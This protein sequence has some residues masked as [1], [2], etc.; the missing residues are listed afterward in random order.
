MARSGV[1]TLRK[2][3]C[4]AVSLFLAA[5]SAVVFPVVAQAGPGRPVQES[6]AAQAQRTGQP[7]LVRSSLSETEERWAQPD[8]SMTWRQYA[9]PVRVRSGEGWTP[10]DLTLVVREDG[11]IAPRAAAVD[12][13]LS[14]G[15]AEEPLVRLGTGGGEVG[16]GWP[17]E[18]PAPLLDGPTATYT[19][20]L[21]DVDVK[22]TAGVLGFSQ[23][24]VVKTEQAAQNPA[25]RRIAFESHTEGVQVSLAEGRGA[26]GKVNGE[27]VL[28]DALTVTD[29]NGDPLYS[30]NGSWMWDS[31]GSATAAERMAGQGE[32]VRTAVMGTELDADTVAIV[33]DQDFLAAAETQYPVYLDPGYSCTSCGK[34]AHAVVQ[35]GYP[36][37]SNYNANTGDLSDLKAG[38]QNADSSGVS[39]TYLEMNTSPIR[40][41]TIHWANLNTTL[42]YSW[43]GPGSATPTELYRAD[44]LNGSTRWNNQ[45]GWVGAK[46][47]ESNATNQGKAPNVSAVFNATAGVQ[48]AVANNTNAILVLKGSSEGNNSSWRRFELNPSLEVNYNSTPN[49]PSG[50]KMQQGTV[51]CVTGPDRPWIATRT[52]Q[53]L[54]NISDPDGQG[55]QVKVATVGGAYGQDVPGTYHDNGR[56]GPWIGTPGP[57]QPALA[58]YTVPGGWITTDGIYKWAMGVYDGEADSP[59]WDWD[60]EF[61]VNSTPPLAPTVTRAF[62]LPAPTPEDPQ[63]SFHQ[64]D[65]STIT[66]E[67]PLATQGLEDIDRF[68]YT[69]DGSQPSAQGSLSVPVTY[70]TN[71]ANQRIAKATFDVTAVNA[72]QNLLRVK[73]VNKAGTAGPNGS[74]GTNLTATGTGADV[75]CFYVATGLSSAARLKGAWSLDEATGPTGG[76]NVAA[77]TSN[78]TP[79]PVSL[80]GDAAW[81]LGYSRGNSWTQAEHFAAKE[82][83]KGGIKVNTTGHLSTAAGQSVID[84]SQSFSVAAWASLSSTT[85]SRT[86]VSQDGSQ[87]SGF[88]LQYSADVGKWSFA[89][90]TSDT[91][92]ATV[93]RATSSDNSAAAQPDVWTHLAGTYDSA[94]RQLVLYVNGK[95]VGT[96]VLPA[97]HWQATGSFIIGA[98]KRNGSR[99]DVLGGLVDD[100]QVWQRTLSDANAHDLATAPVPRAQYGLAGGSGPVLGQGPTGSVLDDTYLDGPVPSLQ[101]NWGFDEAYDDWAADASNNGS[102]YSPNDLALSGSTRVTGHTGSAAHF[103]G[104]AGSYGESASPAVDTSRSF[105]V[106]AWAKVDDLTGYH[107]VVGQSGTQIPGFMIRYS[108]DVQAWIFGMNKADDPGVPAVTE[109]VYKGASVTQPGLWT[110]VTGVFDAI[111]KQMRVYVDGRLAGQRS[112]TGT[113][114][115]ATGPLTVGGYRHN[116]TI[117][118]P[119]KGDVDEVRLWQSALTPSQI[120]A[121]AGIGYLDNV[122]NLSQTATGTPSGNVSETVNADSAALVTGATGSGTSKVTWPRPENLRTDRSFSIEAWVRNDNFA[123][124]TATAVSIS[125]PDHMPVALEYHPELGNG[126]WVFL[127]SYGG[128]QS[129]RQMVSDTTS[130]QGTWT[131]LAGTLDTSSGLACFYVNGQL[132]HTE[133]SQITGALSDV[134]GCSTGVTGWNNNGSIVV[135]SGTWNGNTG[136]QWYGAIAGVRLHSGVRS[137]NAIRDDRTADDPGRIFDITH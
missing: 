81:W 23:V 61:Y 58:Q 98:G 26:S 104:S 45:A 136:L 122:W 132:Q 10:V 90:P 42:A 76:D 11:V 119:F 129:G 8:G 112:F 77:L 1:F 40:G 96:A 53:L 92:N 60:C 68:V 63:P 75:A 125:D 55:L 27:D 113:P 17:A 103:T 30:G 124:G 108:P 131:H 19:E 21:P 33:P 52:P 29:A 73:A 102:G 120:A 13:E 38:Y 74:C 12:L 4:A 69:T 105:T 101:G 15:G 47:G 118:H 86:I 106:S 54:A 71:Q 37:A 115:N 107:G 6:E 25:L 91:A 121:L 128:G 137:V 89:L 24:L 36:N 134:G 3:I 56:T 99:A 44:W 20:V 2:N 117:A 51:P 110:N 93:V 83:T 34:V 57:N 28:G 35:S 18:L 65:K 50:H 5:T 127:I 16:L 123:A 135:G 43:W 14:G 9:Q 59:R 7:V 39:R 133:V 94:S 64:G 41:K 62:T 88:A 84:N 31:S 82:G 49:N 32:G 85:G 95:R 70:H 48:W 22:I 80:A 126:R 67:V 87:N 100:V 109:W 116:G 46:L 97:A 79:H 78:V 114:W 72:L 66:V 130:A 111:T